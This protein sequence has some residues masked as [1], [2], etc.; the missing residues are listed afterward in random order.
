MDWF[1]YLMA[2]W[3]L[4]L[5]GRYFMSGEIVAGL[6]TVAAAIISMIGIL[7]NTRFQLKRDSKTLDRIEATTDK[8]QSNVHNITNKADSLYKQVEK[9]GN[10]LATIVEDIVRRQ[11]RDKANVESA[12]NRDL[13]TAGVQGLYNENVQLNHKVNDLRDENT[14]LH[15]RNAFLEKEVSE[16]KEKLAEVDRK[17]SLDDEADGG[18]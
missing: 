7:I 17:R 2:V 1:L 9:N 13:I 8:T 10:Q 16:L 4:I 14:R 12:S 18:R 3:D 15:V 11:E 6:F 5:A